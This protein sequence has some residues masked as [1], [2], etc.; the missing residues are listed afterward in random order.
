MICKQCGIAVA[1]ASAHE[2]WHA[3]SQATAETRFTCDRCFAEVRE[4]ARD[5]HAWWHFALAEVA[6]SVERLS[7]PV[8]VET[9]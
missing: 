6:F 7:R 8:A 2:A 9:V 1:D 3:A 5:A 4:S